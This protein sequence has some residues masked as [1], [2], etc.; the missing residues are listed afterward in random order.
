MTNEVRERAKAALRRPLT[1]GKKHIPTIY[2]VGDKLFLMRYAAAAYRREFSPRHR[3]E[4]V[5]ILD[6]YEADD[7]SQLPA[8]VRV[9][10]RFEFSD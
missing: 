9:D 6:A 4:T 8:G 7:S 1:F 3:L 10:W 5:S 2:V